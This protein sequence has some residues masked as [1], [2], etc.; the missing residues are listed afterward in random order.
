MSKRIRKFVEPYVVT[1]GH[2]FRLKDFDPDDD[3]G[4][5]GSKEAAASLLDEG[6]RGSVRCRRSCTR[7][8]SGVSC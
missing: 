7:R 4:I 6:S 1:N 8:T 3:G 2:K 5:K